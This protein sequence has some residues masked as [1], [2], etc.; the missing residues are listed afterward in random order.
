[1]SALRLG[2]C[3]PDPH[4]SGVPHGRR[5]RFSSCPGWFP[6]SPELV[7]VR[8]T[9]RSEAVFLQV[10]HP[11]LFVLALGLGV[12]DCHGEESVLLQLLEIM[13]SYFTILVLL[14]IAD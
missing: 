8:E 10:Q 2:H 12:V 7:R 4:T 9:L 11:A 3:L 1:M 14:K 13:N 5:R 6:L